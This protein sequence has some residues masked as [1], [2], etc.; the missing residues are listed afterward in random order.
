MDATKTLQQKILQEMNKQTM[1]YSHEPN[2]MSVDKLRDKSNIQDS[3]KNSSYFQWQPKFGVLKSFENIS[4]KGI[5]THKRFNST[6]VPKQQHDVIDTVDS[7]LKHIPINNVLLSKYFSLAKSSELSTLESIYLSYNK[8][9]INYIK[10]NPNDL[11]LTGAKKYEYYPINYVFPTID[12]NNQALKTK[13]KKNNLLYT[14]PT[15]Q[16]ES[17]EKIGLTPLPYKSRVLMETAK[18]KDDFNSAE[19][20][21]VQMRMVEYTHSLK[22]K[23]ANEQ[24]K[25]LIEDKKRRLLLLLKRSAIIIQKL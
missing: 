12:E 8:N 24:N 1:L 7:Q 19:R 17:N 16:T 18:E 2:I 9:L 3:Q 6:K 5:N 25:K 14:H 15:V 20:C 22:N 13:F 11:K 21:A 10:S 23:Y 4:K